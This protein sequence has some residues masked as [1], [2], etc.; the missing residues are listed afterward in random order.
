[1]RKIMGTAGWKF[2]SAAPEE[3]PREIAAVLPQ[4]AQWVASTDFDVTVT[5][6]AYAGSFYLDRAS[7]QVLFDAVNPVRH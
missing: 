3:V 1:M 7:A 6:G 4:D 5:K 2:T